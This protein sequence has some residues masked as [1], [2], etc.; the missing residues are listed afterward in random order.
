[1]TTNMQ[2][3][4]QFNAKIKAKGEQ[5]N[6]AGWTVTLDWKLPGSQYDLILYG[7]DWDDIKDWEI[8]AT[9]H[10][11]I[12]KGGL[13]KDRQGSFKS[14][15]Y[16]SDYFWNLV[17]NSAEIDFADDEG[18]FVPDDM[19]DLPY[20]DTPPRTSPEPRTQ[21][22]RPA[23]EHVPNPAAIG[24]CQNHAMEMMVTGL[25]PGPEGMPPL[26]W[27]KILRDRI[28]WNVNQQ[29]VGSGRY[30]EV[31][32][33]ETYQGKTGKYGHILE[34]GTPCVQEVE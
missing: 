30:C 5:Q 17:T 20:D 2:D 22:S 12:E 6:K 9:P 10:V 7:Q 16:S 33:V 28:Y 32:L 27:L 8:G 1:M 11:V 19:D 21:A 23:P 31:H 18:G 14:G 25:E 4:Y 26:L 24:A 29:E 15:Q 3:K 34:D 13:K